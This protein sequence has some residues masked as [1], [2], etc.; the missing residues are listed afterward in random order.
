M[1]FSGYG[2]RPD[3]VEVP[4]TVTLVNDVRM[5]YRGAPYHE[6]GGDRNT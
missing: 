3:W 2:R 5:E 1:R 6:E 4:V